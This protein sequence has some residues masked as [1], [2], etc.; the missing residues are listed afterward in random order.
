MGFYGKICESGFNRLEIIGY[1][2][3]RMKRVLDSPVF[4]IRCEY[5]YVNSLIGV[6]TMC[7]CIY[8]YT[9]R[10]KNFS[11]ISSCS[12]SLSRVYI[13][14]VKTGFRERCLP[15]YKLLLTIIALMYMHNSTW[16]TIQQ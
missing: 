5:I 6:Y 12:L 2:N 11:V 1:L 15:D 3:L 14:S 13:I 10:V 7:T 8:V 16:Q 9:D 4:K